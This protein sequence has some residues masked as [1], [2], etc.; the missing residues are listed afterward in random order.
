MALKT[1][2][3][4]TGRRVAARRIERGLSQAALSRR[5][6][7]NS[8]YLS[9]IETG[10]VHPTVRTALRIA[11]ALGFSIEDLVG[12]SPPERRPQPCLVSASGRCMMDLVDPGIGAGRHG[13]AE[14]YSP[15]QVRLLRKFTA[16]LR[17]GGPDLLMA[18]EVLLAE[19]VNREKTG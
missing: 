16:V 11:E 1:S 3:L 13:E 6:G 15:Q 2:Q 19:T 9:R 4:E 10:K 14:V 17:R 18:L 5:T 12:P 7:I 8:S